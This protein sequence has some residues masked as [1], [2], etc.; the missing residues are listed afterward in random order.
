M[1]FLRRLFPA[2]DPEKQIARRVKNW[3]SLLGN[4]GGMGESLACK[5]RMELVQI[6]GPS[7]G[8][9][10][11]A[12]KTGHKP[13]PERAADALGGI[14]DRRAVEALITA[15]DDPD[16]DVCRAAEC[17]LGWIGNVRAVGPLC[18]MLGRDQT[19]SNLAFD[20]FRH[21]PTDLVVGPLITS[22]GDPELRRGAAEVLEAKGVAATSPLLGALDGAAKDVRQT[23]I[24][25][26]ERIKDPRAVDTLVA[27]LYDE[28]PDVRRAA[29]SALARIGDRRAVA[30]LIAALEEGAD[31]AP[32]VVNAL[33]RLGGSDAQQALREW[34]QKVNN[35]SQRL[36]LRAAQAEVARRNRVLQAQD[37]IERLARELVD[38]G[39]RDGFLRSRPGNGFDAEG[40]H[41]RS[42]A[43]GD[44]LHEIG[45]FTLMQEVCDVTRKTLG[46][47]CAGGAE[48]EVAWHGIGAWQS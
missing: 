28:E 35:E 14:G 17:A 25:V 41:I 18:R 20:A 29:A 26:L 23:I 43:I 27:E 47:A 13:L 5:A 6:G 24:E 9:L 38:I 15:L 30:P 7:V 3:I 42:R 10:V 16:A 32:G 48:L 31:G 12:L 46:P 21:F 45:G 34:R 39:R 2:P 36:K 19:R 44:R 22:L 37:E 11:A 4:P 33:E 40:R 1:S 8:P